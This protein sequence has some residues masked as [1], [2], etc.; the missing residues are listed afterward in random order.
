MEDVI[1]HAQSDE[2]TLS[3][4]MQ[5]RP[6]ITAKV[7]GMLKTMKQQ[8]LKL[9]GESYE[10]TFKSE[11]I[12]ETQELPADFDARVTMQVSDAVKSEIEQVAAAEEYVAFET[13]FSGKLPG[14][15]TLQ[16][17]V[18]KK[19]ANQTMEL[20][21][22]PEGAKAE[23]IT[24]VVVGEDGWVSIPLEHCSV[25]FLMVKSDT[26]PVQN[27]LTEST[28]SSMDSSSESVA[29]SATDS[30]Q[31]DNSNTMTEIAVLWIAGIAL[32][33]LVGIGGFVILNKKRK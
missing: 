26:G 1:Q 16:I 14:K 8:E 27:E 11:D 2:N 12:D 7:F 3:F 18:D 5:E 30:V 31:I 33:L 24:E 13:A 29:E 15:A 25:Y 6:T 20:Y 22:Q 4:D 21:Y 19:F 32:V 17:Q 23:A 9:Q 28:D 10:W